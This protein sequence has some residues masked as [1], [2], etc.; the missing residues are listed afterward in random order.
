MIDVIPTGTEPQVVSATVRAD[1]SLELPASS[2][3]AYGL[4]PR[5]HAPAFGRV[6]HVF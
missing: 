2:A 4:S 3:G 6:P 5:Q 1:F